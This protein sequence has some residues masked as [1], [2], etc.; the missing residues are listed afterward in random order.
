MSPPPPPHQRRRPPGP[1]TIFP[2]FTFIGKGRDPLTAFTALAR[3][4][5]DLVQFR[6]L[7]GRLFLLN[8]PDTIH[9]VL[10][11][12]SRRFAKGRA[13]ERTRPVLGTGLL[14]SEGAFHLRQRRLMQPA[15]HQQRIAEFATTMTAHADRL[16]A[17]WQV[18]ET[19]DLAVDMM[20][21]TLGIVGETL[22]GAEVDADAARVR[23]ALNT[24]M[25]GF[26]LLMLPFSGLLQRLP[27]PVMRR[28]RAARADLDGII[29][30][31]INAR[32]ADGT[33][34]GD[35]LSMLLAAQ[36]PESADPAAGM[37]DAEVRD[38]VMT[39]FLAGHETTANALAWTW[40][41]LAGHPEI[42]AKLHAELR[43]VLPG[44]RLPTHAD[45]PALVY[46]EQVVREAMRLY[47][48]A[49]LISRRA[50]ETCEIGGYEIP[51]GSI[52]VMSQ[53][54][55]HRDARWFPDPET[56]RPERWTPEFKNALPRHAYFPFGGGPRRCIGEGFAWME[57]IL[58]VARI[59]SRW[60]FTRLD[61][62]PVVPEPLITLRPANGLPMRLEFSPLELR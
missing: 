51:R 7:S 11:T 23:A 10:V 49:W 53:W 34:H 43:E 15:F 54:V 62:T 41:L 27:L 35:L 2:A 61:S 48:P 58:L 16:T 60:R 57:L 42:E 26:P 31:L 39:I 22:F 8:H 14:T 32:R 24:V 38:E 6:G 21:L 56:F 36:D 19:R 46:T 9:D 30:A 13:L 45:Q 28:L 59:A 29:Y 4:Y 47:P 1:R 17:G 40:H 52:V 25:H 20:R 18:G 12:R 5:G 3:R 33:D 44:N 37:T 55:T 50:L